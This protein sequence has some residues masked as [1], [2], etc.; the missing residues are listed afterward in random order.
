M[1]DKIFVKCPLCDFEFQ[2]GP[3]RYEGHVLESYGGIMVCDHCW[4]GNWDGWTPLYE[5]YLRAILKNKNLPV[6]ERNEK[7]LLPRS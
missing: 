2:H 7:G 4:G 5:D 1:L 6:P 3:Q